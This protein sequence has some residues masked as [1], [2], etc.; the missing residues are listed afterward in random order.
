MQ[1]TILLLGGY[2][3]T[4]GAGVIRDYITAV[5]FDVIPMGII[6]AYTVQGPN[7]VKGVFERKPEEVREEIYYLIQ[8]IKFGG[9]KAGMIFSE[10]IARLLEE[11]VDRIRVPLILDLVINSKN[12]FPLI[13]PQTLQFLLNRLLE[14]IYVLHI[15]YSEAK[16][17]SETLYNDIKINSFCDALEFSKE[18][19]S[20]GCKY[21]A[22]TCSE[23]DN[24]VDAL[25]GNEKI[26]IY[27]SDKIDRKVHGTGCMFTTALASA[28]V[29]GKDV[30]EAFNIARN[31]VRER[32]LNSIKICEDCFYISYK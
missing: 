31:Y 22:L 1:K 2:D 7:G 24:T 29:S 12:N 9:I 19:V 14:K 15:N 4:G 17:I 16:I 28:I 21:V 18:L 3:P 10:N 30:L 25:V 5:H 27:R 8:N 23:F 32:I 11:I 13:R 6:T 26:I 20:K